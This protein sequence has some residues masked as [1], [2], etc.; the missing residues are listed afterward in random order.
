MNI[1]IFLRLLPVLMMV[2]LVSNL[3]G[4]AWAYPAEEAK[5]LDFEAFFDSALQEQMA[6]ENIVGAAAAVVHQGELAFAKGY[7]YADMEQRLPVEADRTL[8]FV[9]SDGKLLTWTAVMQ[10]VEKGKVDLHADVNNYLDFEIPPAFDAPVTL[11]HLMT[12]TAGFEEEFNSLFRSGPE[13]I[14]PLR[15]H[16]VRFMPARVYPPGRVSAYSNYGTALAGYIIERVS[17]Q[18]FEVYLLEHIL[19]PLAMDNSLIGSRP[20]SGQID[21]AAKGYRTQGGKRTGVD[22]EWTASVPC[23]PLH[24]TVVDMS[25]FMLAHLNG[26]CAKSGCILKEDTLR[27]MHSSQFAHHPDMTGFAYGFLEM[28]IN[29]RRMLWHLGESPSFITILAL[30]PEEQ[31]GVLVTY[32]TSP[33]DARGIL[34]KF[35]EAFFPVQLPVSETPVLPGWKE[36][37]AAFNGVYVEARSAHTSPQIAARYL[38]AVPVRI[39][40]GRLVF[41]RWQFR[42]T[43]PG[44]FYQV[45]GERKLAFKADENGTRWLLLG[46]LAYF[47]LPWYETP[48]FLLS[49][50]GVSLL[51]YLSAWAAWTASAF[52]R[53]EKGLRPRRST[54]WLAT[55]L[56]LFEF[57]IMGWLAAA[58]L[59]FGENFVF[60]SNGVS[61]LSRL[62]WL[63]LPWTLLVLALAVRACVRREWTTAWRVHYSLAAVAGAALLWLLWVFNLLS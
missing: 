5:M 2:G 12:H 35:M 27:L 43:Q 58:L 11:H 47:K 39:D 50:A 36:R 45:G 21:R 38:K 18:S 15:E 32:N 29:G 31:L 51:V 9:G 62:A 13:E 22:F 41:N 46:P 17:G 14:L 59:K 24:T 42:E 25:R 48:L 30:S 34:V 40:Q 8:F 37:A 26:G 23:A 19:K 55:G 3:A 4:P 44:L 16:L 49:L 33:A 1:K 60:P 20:Q 53:K 56:G 28:Q 7:G 52:R 6:A 10:L 61:L 63:A 57:G 54:L